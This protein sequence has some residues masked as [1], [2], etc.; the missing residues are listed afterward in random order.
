[1]VQNAVAL[2]FPGLPVSHNCSVS[3][4]GYLE[5]SWR[6]A[7]TLALFKGAQKSFLGLNWATGP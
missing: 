1:M 7:P 5:V 4:N 3:C 6:C 2:V